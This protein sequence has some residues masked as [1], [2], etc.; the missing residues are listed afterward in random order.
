MLL[1]LKNTWTDHGRL[2]AAWHPSSCQRLHQTRH[3]LQRQLCH[4][5]R[6]CCL[7]LKGHGGVKGAW[8]HIMRQ[9]A[10]QRY[11]ARFDVAR[12]Y[13]SIDH[14]ILLRIMRQLPPR[15]LSQRSSLSALRSAI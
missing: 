14:Q 9:Q 13:E 7:H 8:R 12:Y 10:N 2:F 4:S 3:H 6:R 15:R 11:V 5:L 1:S